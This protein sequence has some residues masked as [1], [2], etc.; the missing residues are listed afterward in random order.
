MS[1]DGYTLKV[2]V[3]SFGILLFEL[4]SLIV[5]FSNLFCNANNSNN[6]N[7][8]T[9]NKRKNL[10]VGSRH[11][12]P[13][14]KASSPLWKK[15]VNGINNRRHHRDDKS[16]GP[17][18]NN[19]TTNEISSKFNTGHTSTSRTRMT[20]EFYRQVVEQ[21]IRPTDNIDFLSAVPCPR[22]RSLIVE[23]WQPDPTKRP[24]FQEIV[25]RL[26][27]ILFYSKGIVTVNEFNIPRDRR[28]TLPYS[29]MGWPSKPRTRNKIQ[30]QQ[31][32][33]SFASAIILHPTQSARSG[34]LQHDERTEQLETSHSH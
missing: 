10:S 3:Y 22:L 8:T 4:C 2:D 28:T 19:S 6:G 7:S 13:L 27:D 32:Y 18:C 16:Y 25:P 5:P 26:Q 29:P 33:D 20:K 9:T 15:I 21:E 11:L 17:D 34:S 14:S 23:C 30:L 31:Q 1:G 12:R 24:A